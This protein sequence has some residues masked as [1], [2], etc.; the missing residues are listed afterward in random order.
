MHLQTWTKDWPQAQGIRQEQR[1]GLSTQSVPSSSFLQLT[2]AALE[3]NLVKG[4]AIS[5]C[6]MPDLQDQTN[7]GKR[8]T[9]II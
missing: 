7:Q 2:Q 1:L 6:G 4:H 8:F 5:K 3:L 9:T